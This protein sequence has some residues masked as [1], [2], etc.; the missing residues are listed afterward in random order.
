MIEKSI[1]EG[2]LDLDRMLKYVEATLEGFDR[3]IARV[4]SHM[5]YR[6]RRIKTHVSEY[7]KVMRR[8][9]ADRRHRVRDLEA[10]KA[11]VSTGLVKLEVRMIENVN[12]QLESAESPRASSQ[13]YPEL[14]N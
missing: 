7:N 13:S 1:T 4:D 10:F 8:L 9:E 5:S 11:N 14:K 2:T 12:E 6:L 3:D